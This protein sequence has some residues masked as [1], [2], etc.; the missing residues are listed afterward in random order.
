MANEKGIPIN[1]A[2][3]VA[4]TDSDQVPLGGR[5]GL[6][7]AAKAV[8]EGR[9]KYTKSKPETPAPELAKF[10]PEQAAKAAETICNVT[11]KPLC[12]MFSG[13]NKAARQVI[14]PEFDFTL[15]EIEENTFVDSLTSCF[16]TMPYSVLSKWIP[17]ISLVVSTGMITYPRIMAV[18]EIRK[19]AKAGMLKPELTVDKPKAEKEK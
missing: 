4:G 3:S 6:S 2:A 8:K 7:A 5:Q 10:T 9:R 14:A 13:L 17:W 15:S 16:E 19:A 18:M 1:T 12:G 11:L